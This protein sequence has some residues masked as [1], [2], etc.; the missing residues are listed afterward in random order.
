M[1]WPSVPWKSCDTIE[2]SK[3]EDSGEDILLSAGAKEGI[4]TL[5]QLIYSGYL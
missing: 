1:F 5:N 3:F 4:N 2:K